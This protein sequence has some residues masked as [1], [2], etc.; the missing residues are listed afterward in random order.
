MKNKI[1]MKTLPWGF[2]WKKSQRISNK[3][4]ESLRIYCETVTK[5]EKKTTE[6]RNSYI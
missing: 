2:R 6:Y 4:F 5:I 3:N 1:A